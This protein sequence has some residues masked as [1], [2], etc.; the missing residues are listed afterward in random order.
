MYAN[1]F[2]YTN[3]SIL[4]LQFALKNVRNKKNKEKKN[5]NHQLQCQCTM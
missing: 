5:H 2:T 3:L 4:S 1:F